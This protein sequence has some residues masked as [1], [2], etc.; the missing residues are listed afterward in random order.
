MVTVFADSVD[1]LETR[2]SWAW[3]A[4]RPMLASLQEERTGG[5]QRKRDRGRDGRDVAT[6]PRDAWSTRS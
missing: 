4:P 2:S 1:D 3:R 6:S 5:T